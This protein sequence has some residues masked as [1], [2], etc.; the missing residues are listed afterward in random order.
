MED[1]KG[2]VSAVPIRSLAAKFSVFSGLLVFWVVATIFL[3]DLSKD[4]FDLYKACF[5]LLVILLVAGAISRY[6]IRLLVRPLTNLQLGIDAVQQG[7]L[8]PVR[9][10]RTGDEIEF[11]G[12][13]FN[14]MIAALQ[15]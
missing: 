11:L 6:T 8:E 14:Q 10:S 15:S 3:Y 1:R 4:S 7:R 5:L 13:S 12:N 2:G 9:V